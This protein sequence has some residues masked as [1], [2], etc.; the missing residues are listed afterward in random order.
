MIGAIECLDMWP[1]AATP[2]GKVLEVLEDI[3]AGHEASTEDIH[4]LHDLIISGEFMNTVSAL[5]PAFWWVG[6]SSVASVHA[7]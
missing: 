1:A 7:N 5:A 3:M 2:I 6:L 4:K